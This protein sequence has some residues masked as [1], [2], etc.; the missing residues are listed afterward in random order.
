MNPD[1]DIRRDQIKADSI[2]LGVQPLAR[3]SQA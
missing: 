1:P 3:F 2:L